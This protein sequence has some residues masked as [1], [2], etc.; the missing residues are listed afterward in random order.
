MAFSQ[1]AARKS[2]TKEGGVSEARLEQL[3]TELDLA[4]GKIEALSFQQHTNQDRSAVVFRQLQEELKDVKA[5][6]VN[7][8]KKVR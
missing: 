1:P 3:E 6:L 8:A 4:Y 7:K 5:Q 2:E